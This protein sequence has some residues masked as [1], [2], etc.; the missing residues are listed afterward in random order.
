M[1]ILKQVGVLLVSMSISSGVLAQ[2]NGE[3][4]AKAEVAAAMQ[5]WKHAMM[6]KDEKGLDKVFN[7]NLQYGH[8]TGEVQD[9]PTTIKRDMGSP[10][11]YTGIEFTDTKMSIYGNVAVVN[12]KNIFHIMMN[13]KPSDISFNALAV[14]VKDSKMGWQLRARQVVKAP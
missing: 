7:V 6:T 12:G 4:A 3:A 11:T 8:S 1:S 13:G 14:W 2:S 10:N 9:K 5:A